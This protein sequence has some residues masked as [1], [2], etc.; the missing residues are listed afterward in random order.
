MK[1]PKPMPGMQSAAWGKTRF[2]P[3]GLLIL[4]EDSNLLVV[5]KPVGLLSVNDPKG[6]A[7]SA[8]T[9]LKDYIRKGNSKS[10]RKLFV[11]HRL[12]RDASGV[13]VFAKSETARNRLMAQWH[14]AVEKTYIALVWGRLT[15]KEGR[16]SSFLVEDKGLRVRSSQSGGKLSHTQYCVQ[17][18]TQLYSV[19]K[20]NLQTGR[21]HQIRVHLAEAGHPILGDKR[22]GPKKRRHSRLALHALSIAFPHPVGGKPMVIESQLPAFFFKQ[23]GPF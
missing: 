17:K 9:A 23:V 12:D 6:K 4:H 11:V 1:H 21:K 8:F 15:Q 20:I 14:T 5:D 10:T 18:E 7:L 2:L 19:V 13:L 22:Y 16:F 3:R